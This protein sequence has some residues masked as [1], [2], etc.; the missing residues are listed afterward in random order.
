MFFNQ[1]L[2]LAFDISIYMIYL[3]SYSCDLEWRQMIREVKR[4][5]GTVTEKSGWLGSWMDN[6]TCST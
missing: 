6:T 1:K 5:N 2:T 4:K 3:D